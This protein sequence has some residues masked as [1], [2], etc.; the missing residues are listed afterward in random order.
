MREEWRVF[1]SRI[2]AFDDEFAARAKN[3][4]N[5]DGPRGAWRLSPASRAERDGA[6]CGNR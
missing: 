4:A 1:D 2:A 5:N 3:R 6:C